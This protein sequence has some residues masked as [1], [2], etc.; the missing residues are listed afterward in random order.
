MIESPEI[1]MTTTKSD[2]HIS[3]GYHQREVPIAPHSS[4]PINFVVV[5]VANP[6]IIHLVI[7]GLLRAARIAQNVHH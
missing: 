6:N 2:Q 4:K 5:I 7:Y 3:L 1:N